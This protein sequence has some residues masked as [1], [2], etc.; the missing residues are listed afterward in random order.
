MM[1]FESSR[2]GTLKQGEHGFHVRMCHTANQ[3][4]K[5]KKV[6]THIYARKEGTL[7]YVLLPV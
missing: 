5:K 2:S 3:A 4:I 6:V 7:E 1:Y